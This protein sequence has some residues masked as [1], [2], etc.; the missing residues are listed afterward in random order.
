MYRFDTQ[1]GQL[2]YMGSFRITDK[3][4]AMFCIKKGADYL[5]TVTAARPNDSYTVVKGDTLSRIAFR[6]GISLKNLLE[7]NPQI[8]NKNKIWVGDK[9]VLP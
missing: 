5:I 1:S 4:Q 8:V 2:L 3:G 6:Y 9:I 7:A